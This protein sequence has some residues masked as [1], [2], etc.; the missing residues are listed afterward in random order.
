M[1]LCKLSIPYLNGGIYALITA[2]LILV[3]STFAAAAAEADNANFYGIDFAQISRI[4]FWI[5]IYIR[6]AVSLERNNSNCGMVVG[7]FLVL[8]L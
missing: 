7:Y 1:H 5:K 2:D 8:T 4:D 3:K 6:L